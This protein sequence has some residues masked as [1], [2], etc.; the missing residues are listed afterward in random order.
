MAEA[1]F[2]LIPPVSGEADDV[3][4]VKTQILVLHVAKLAVD[5]QGR[6]QRAM[7]KANCPT[8]RTFRTRRRAERRAGRRP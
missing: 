6:G 4:P 5:D 7:V 3:M 2:S 8:T 1:K